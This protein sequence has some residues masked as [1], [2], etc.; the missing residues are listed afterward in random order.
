MNSS[1]EDQILEILKEA[2]HFQYLAEISRSQKDYTSE[3]DHLAEAATLLQRVANRADEPILDQL[4]SIGYQF[5]KLRQYEEAHRVLTRARDVAISLFGE[6][7]KRVIE[8]TI[9]LAEVSTEQNDLRQ[10]ENLY[11]EAIDAAKKLKSPSFTIISALESYA[12]TLARHDRLNDAIEIMREAVSRREHRSPWSINTARCYEKYGGMLAAIG[13]KEEAREA[14]LHSLL[15]RDEKNSPSFEYAASLE[16]FADFLEGVGEFEEARK[17]FNE[18]GRIRQLAKEPDRNPKE[19]IIEKNEYD[20]KGGADSDWHTVDYDWH[21]VEHKKG[22]RIS[23]IS[24]HIQSA[25]DQTSLIFYQTTLNATPIP[26]TLS[27]GVVEYL[28]LQALSIHI[29]GGHNRIGE[30]LDRAINGLRNDRSVERIVSLKSDDYPSFIDVLCGMVEYVPEEHYAVA[31]SIA[32]A[33]RNDNA[34]PYYGSWEWLTPENF[35]IIKGVYTF[36]LDQGGTKILA[37]SVAIGCSIIIIRICWAASGVGA[38]I[39]EA[40]GSRLIKQIEAPIKDE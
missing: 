14:L 21:T 31:T 20:F 25:S 29:R 39:I 28:Q 38:N 30:T 12:N 5:K 26:V 32:N 11:I 35:N 19:Q 24:A 2:K 15:I 17:Y 3:I 22:D 23:D 33:M 40:I 18:A 7:D 34:V 9:A 13:R 27:N 8:Y 6:I 4:R 10:A 37:A 1:D 36:V 16:R